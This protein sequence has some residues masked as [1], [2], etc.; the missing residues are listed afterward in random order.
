MTTNSK[1]AYFSSKTRRFAD[2]KAVCFLLHFL[3]VQI[4]MTLGA[5]VCYLVVRLISGVG[6][7]ITAYEPG[8]FLF[9]VGDVLF[10]TVPVIAWMIF[11]GHGWRHSLGIAAAMIAP[12]AAILV[13]GP[14]TTYDYLTW[15][16]TAGYPA[17]SLGMLTYM[18]YHHDLFTGQV[19]RLVNPL[20][21]DEGEAAVS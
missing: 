8:T 7:F 11:R 12:V 21:A 4:S 9:A 5:L 13:L 16:L 15:L 6:S 14:L 20:P 3:E 17:M 1:Q 10:L 18:L 2:S 19:S